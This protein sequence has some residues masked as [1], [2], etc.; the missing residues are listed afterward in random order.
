ML[1]ENLTCASSGCRL[2]FAV[3]TIAGCGDI[4]SQHDGVEKGAIWEDHLV[5]ETVI[6]FI[7]RAAEDKICRI[8]KPCPA[9]HQAA[10][11]R[12]SQMALTSLTMFPSIMCS[13]GIHTSSLCL[14]SPFG[15]HLALRS[16]FSELCQNLHVRL[17]ARALSTW[18]AHRLLS[19]YHHH[20]HEH[21]GILPNP[22]ACVGAQLMFAE[23]IH[24]G[25]L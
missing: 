14:Y 8:R 24:N 22:K 3:G 6:Y 17:S 20:H 11:L 23:L 2:I 19:V 12:V 21:P 9:S 15:D 4:L 18:K 1:G 7:P 13:L 16:R 5:Q 10:L 25:Q